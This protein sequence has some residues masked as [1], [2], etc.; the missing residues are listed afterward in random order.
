[1][2]NQEDVNCFFRVS[3]HPEETK[4]PS[5]EGLCM[6]TISSIRVSGHPGETINVDDYVVTHSILQE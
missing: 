6:I 2:C 3:G 4:R 1:M 5:I